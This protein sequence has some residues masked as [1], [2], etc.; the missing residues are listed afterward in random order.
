MGGPLHTSIPTHARSPGGCKH[1]KG[2]TYPIPPP[3]P[4]IPAT[5]IGFDG[6]P[7]AWNCRS[8][9]LMPRTAAP[10]TRWSPATV[11]SSSDPAVPQL[12]SYRRKNPISMPG[13]RCI[14]RQSQVRTWSASCTL[15]CAPVCIRIAL[16][17]EPPCRDPTA[18]YGYTQDKE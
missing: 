16:I 18:S 4:C 6:A 5:S 13:R 7:L 1:N 3:P 15:I 2:K 12:G 10:T 8:C 14:G 11:R 9:K 17:T